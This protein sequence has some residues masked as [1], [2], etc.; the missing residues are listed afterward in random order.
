MADFFQTGVVST[1]HRLNPNGLH[2]I[3]AELE[4]FAK[5]RP[6]GLVLPALYSEFKTPAMRGI[7][8]EL[9]HVKYLNRVVVALGRANLDEYRH[10]MSFFQDFP[11][12]VTFL[13]IDSARVQAL[14]RRL[15]ERGLTAGPDG[16]GRSCWLSY[17]Y[18]LAEA[19]C[20]MIALHDCDILNYSR[21]LLAR[22]CYP[23]ANPNLGYEFC[24]GYYARV[25]EG[26]NGRVTRLFMT[27][28][29]RA[30][31]NMA[32]SLP[33]LRFLDSFRYPL[34]GEFAMRTNLARVNPVRGD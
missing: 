5:T 14:F 33:F 2:R 17:G 16:K 19:E 24:K 8:D 25:G 30:L 15:E 23:V 10:A 21:E 4:G 9:S 18:L 22:L 26:M 20:K 1:L 27:P 31:E 12:P 29:V 7:I 6:I 11:I 32:P 34:A 3:E 28:L 13:W